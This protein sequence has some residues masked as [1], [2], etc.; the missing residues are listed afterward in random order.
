MLIGWPLPPSVATAPSSG[1]QPSREDLPE[2]T[3]SSLLLPWLRLGGF[4]PPC[5]SNAQSHQA[6][7][8]QHLPRTASVFPLGYSPVPSLL[9]R[10]CPSPSASFVGLPGGKTYRPN[11]SASFRHKTPRRSAPTAFAS[12]GLQLAEIAI[13]TLQ[14]SILCDR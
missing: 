11:T 4:F 5:K 2:A 1:I 13:S 6:R 7:P 10:R 12:Y 9:L 14:S 3:P 8:R